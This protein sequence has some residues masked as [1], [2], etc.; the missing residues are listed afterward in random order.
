MTCSDSG[1][2]ECE[3]TGRH[4]RLLLCTH[5]LSMLLHGH[6]HVHPFLPAVLFPSLA[7][8]LARSR[9]PSAAQRVSR[10]VEGAAAVSGGEGEGRAE[11]GLAS[12]RRQGGSE[13][14]REARTVREQQQQQQAH[15][16]CGPLRTESGGADQ[17]RH[18]ARIC[19]H[20]PVHPAGRDN[21]PVPH[22]RGCK[23]PE[24]CKAHQGRRRLCQ[25]EG[26]VSLRAGQGRSGTGPASSSARVRQT[27]GDL[28]C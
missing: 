11:E 16:T 7:R 14:R 25:A 4:E 24:I 1:D 15:H 13:T 6:V 21:Q 22:P 10:R 5:L 18:W 26:R 9:V 8:L 20:C 3:R 19:S 28:S 23:G 17:S 2:F 12:R 27:L